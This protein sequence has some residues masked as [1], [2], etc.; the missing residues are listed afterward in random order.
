MIPS[1]RGRG[2][3]TAI[4]HRLILQIS[5]G[6]ML[7]AHAGSTAAAQFWERLDFVPVADRPY[8]HELMAQRD[9]VLEVS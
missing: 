4:A 6:T 5:A 1:F 3:G 9:A 2:V 8:S 7:T